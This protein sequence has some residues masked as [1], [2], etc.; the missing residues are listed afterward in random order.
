MRLLRWMVRW[1][2]AA[3]GVATIVIALSFAFW[4]ALGI[5]WLFEPTPLVRGLMWLGVVIS[6]VWISVRTLFSRVFT[7]LPDSSLALL[8]E[9]N[10]PELKES[11]VT[12][13]EAA[14]VMRDSPVGN[15][16]MLRQTS[17]TAAE[18]IHDVSLWRIFRFRPLAWK[19]G[20]ALTLL[21]SIMLFG[22]LA[23]ESM[24]FWI[25]RMKLAE[26]LWPRNVHL[27]VE[28][29]EE[30]N[31]LRVVNVARDDDLELQV[32][33]SIERGFVA[34]DVVEIRYQLVDGRRGRDNLI[35]V[36]EALPGR[37][38]AQLFRY[39]FQNVANDLQFDLVGDDDRISGLR[40]HVVER[41]K[42]ER[43]TLDCEFP[44]Y[45]DRGPR[46]IPV[47]G[48]VE[49]PEGT[50]AVCHLRSNKS[51]ESIRVHDPASQSD[52]EARIDI[53]DPHEL[54]FDL[55]AGFDDQVL[56]ITIRDT[57]GVENRDPFRMVVSVIPDLPP[58]V[59]VALR[60][61]GSAVTPQAN[62]PLVGSVIDDYGLRSIWFEYLIDKNPPERLEMSTQPLASSKFTDFDS[63][64]LAKTNPETMKPVVA[65]AA[66]QKLTLA[67]QASDAYDL[68]E[69]PHVGSSQRFFLDVVTDSELR[70][71]LEKRELSLRQRFE[72]IYEKMVGTRELLDRIDAQRNTTEDKLIDE[73]EVKRRLQRDRLRIGGCLQ[74]ATQ[75]SYETVGVAEGFEEIVAELINNRVVT[76]ELR[77][78]LEQGI[79]EPLHV[80]GSEL[81]PELETR[82]QHLE[83][84]YEESVE[85]GN[86]F[87]PAKEQ[88]EAVVEAMKRVLDRML[89]LESYNELVELLRGIVDGQKQLGEQTQQERR[90]KLRS[91]LGDE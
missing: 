69:Q 87:Q 11:L 19:A 55:T 6:V 58:E 39:T 59:S 57:E 61:I 80:I 35:K 56:L 3:E 90:D 4:L 51:L 13:V 54:Q 79:A 2:V 21:I 86:S 77:R 67:I 42:V 27:S 18:A 38:Q 48:R 82:L 66:G 20:L 53:D 71:L 9:R 84:V 16:T 15:P 72:A 89:E 22:L 5:D 70:A 83:E 24:G 63:L 37:D 40:L 36:G 10:Y 47:S 43:I 62:I 12:T 88:S 41:P 52:L 50:R 1:Y 14:D 91:I 17:S 28:G 30:R 25:E 85:P 78:R 34:P 23:K 76:E 74:N 64:D 7:R 81:L 31:G 68:G 45:M 29:F 75:L 60:G 44:A 46:T 8:V 33:A 32:R 49:L 65:L 26:E 73:E